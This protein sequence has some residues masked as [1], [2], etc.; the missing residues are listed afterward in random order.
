[1]IRPGLLQRTLVMSLGA[2][3]GV[4][5]PP[6]AGGAPSFPTPEAYLRYL[7]PYPDEDD[8]SDY[9]SEANGI[10]H[11][12][13]N[14]YITH[15]S[16]G[17]R[18]WRVP[19]SVP[20]ADL[21]SSHPLV[22]V[23]SINQMDNGSENLGDLGYNHYGDLGHYSYAGTD[24]L[25]IGMSGGPCAAVIAVRCV[26]GE[27]D[28]LDRACINTVSGGL[29]P[30]S[31][32]CDVGP[33]GF[34]YSSNFGWADGRAIDNAASHIRKYQVDWARLYTHGELDLTLVESIQV[35][36]E[37][38]FA[39]PLFHVQGGAVTPSG[40][41]LYIGCGYTKN[42]QASWGLHA[43]EITGDRGKNGWTLRQSAD[44]HGLF[45]FSI[46]DDPA[47]SEMEGITI[48]DLDD[49]RAQGI[50]GQLHALVLDN[51]TFNDDDISIRHYGG[52]VYVD[53]HEASGN[54]KVDDPYP[55]VGEANNLVSDPDDPWNGAVLRIDG[56]NY[57][58]SITFDTQVEVVA[59]GTDAN[60]GE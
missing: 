24:Y 19:V 22:T 41:V 28:Y 53:S 42:R 56:G 6:A 35:K 11:D 32:W 59:P 34:L 58:E 8:D 55:T 50:R 36:S 37:T 17:V 47:D 52:S 45:N 38:G 2:A 18:L 27:F 16:Y 5:V 57:P 29:Q 13:G 23:T 3:I 40:K 21:S 30:S 60:I 51:D 10:T 31:P 1:M 46:Y 14:W 43:I 39:R 26:G 49:G 12:D 7:G 48:W 4:A 54:G 20:L 33:S 15:N 9:G 25:L 44:G